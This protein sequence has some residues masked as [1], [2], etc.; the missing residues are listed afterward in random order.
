MK[1]SIFFQMLIWV[2]AHSAVSSLYVIYR[3]SINYSPDDYH[4]CKIKK[5][6]AIKC[7][8]VY[9]VVISTS[10]ISFLEVGN[11]PY[12]ALRQV[13]D[14]LKPRFPGRWI[15]H[16]SPDSYQ[17]CRSLDITPSFSSVGFIKDTA[18]SKKGL[19]GWGRLW[20]QS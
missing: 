2:N 13:K 5:E 15:G 19:A 14:C 4:P 11:T 20:H 3:V 16:D 10:E 9:V 12:H 8:G 6:I 1:A 18:Y 7:N 17:S